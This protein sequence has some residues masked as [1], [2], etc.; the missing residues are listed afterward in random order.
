MHLAAVIQLTCTSDEPGNL[1]TAESLI[2]RAA[3]RGAQ[4]IATPEN[5]NFLG[6]H[7]DKVRRSEPLD[8]PI[9]TRLSALARELGVHLLIGSL[10]EKSDDPERCYNT[11][12]LFGPDGALL[13]SYRK[14]HLFDVDVSDEVRFLE[15]NTCVAG[16]EPVVVNT[17]LGA[18]G[19]S[20][21]Y[22]LRF[23]GLYAELVRRG[24][25]I[26]AVPSA[27]TLTTGKDHWEVLLRARAIE[28]Q[29]YVLAPGQHGFH[30]DGGLRNSYGHSMIVDPW[31]HV[32]G[33]A[34][35]GPGLAFAEI[36]LDRV[37]SVRRG[38]PV[39]DHRR[40]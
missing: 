34:S 30:D 14:I 39:N 4:L 8:G 20:I 9:G 13:G 10:N 3:S 11:S 7:R 37:R 21:C 2:R 17:A 38:M 32:V 33:R 36:D 28:T 16:E 22:D 18:I 6:P 24:A 40:F 15:S 35:D 1:A 5:T 23:P 27:F 31:G 25:E 12:A 19:L 29:C 26:L